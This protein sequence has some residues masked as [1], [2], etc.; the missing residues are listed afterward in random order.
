V[1]QS[2]AYT[3]DPASDADENR[4]L[5][6]PLA[7]VTL[8]EGLRLSQDDTAYTV[9]RDHVS[10]L[11]YIRS[12]RELHDRGLYVDLG[13]YG[14]HVFLDFYE[15]RDSA[16]QPYADLTAHL[17][18]R[19]VPSIAEALREILL[20][21]I[22]IAFR[23]LV[24]A[25]VARRFMDEQITEPSQKPGA[26]ASDL[27]DEMQQAAQGLLT[28]IAGYLVAYV[29]LSPLMGRG[30]RAI[31][32]DMRR[33]LRLLLS[34]PATVRV[35][36]RDTQGDVAA[37]AREMLGALQN[38]PVLWGGSLVWG[39]CRFM[40]ELQLPADS[41]QLSAEW[42]V[43]LLLDRVVISEFNALGMSQD[44]AELTTRVIRLLARHGQWIERIVRG[45][46]T[47]GD[48]LSAWLADDEMQSFL[49]VNRYE[50]ALWFNRERFDILLHWFERLAFLDLALSAGENADA[51]EARPSVETLERPLSRLLQVAQAMRDAE[52]A[53]GYRVDALLKGLKA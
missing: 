17:A 7:R 37:L 21:P 51:P 41:R 32:A 38:D 12:N 46:A 14:C 35:L 40:G 1:R 52:V 19:G 36:Q 50:D 30:P 5:E 9:F 15:V 27:L 4:T 8:G 26:Q 48:L 33:A 43:E 49:L 31:A 22:H 16:L 34:L 45:A 2:V 47:G 39:S 18:G 20:Q 11:E 28:E 13:A 24:G 3:T 42:M 6:R 53:S 25:A 10:G 29:D 44:E 23:S